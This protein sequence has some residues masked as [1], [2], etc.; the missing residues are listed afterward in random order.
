MKPI[1][2]ALAT[3]AALAVGA[4]LYVMLTSAGVPPYDPDDASRPESA[5]GP[6]ET[7]G[8]R[9]FAGEHGPS[10]NGTRTPT[11][12]R[13]P[14]PPAGGGAGEEIDLDARFP[15]IDSVEENGPASGVEAYRSRTVRGRV[16]D[17]SGAAIEGARVVALARGDPAERTEARTDVAGAFSIRTRS[18]DDDR[19]FE[20]TH[21]GYGR[22]TFRVR[23]SLR[24]H[25]GETVDVGDLVLE[26]GGAIAGHLRTTEG[27]PVSSLEVVLLGPVPGSDATAGFVAEGHQFAVRRSG[28]DGAFAFAGLSPG[29]YSL[30]VHP[31][32]GVGLAA[33]SAEIV[34]AEGEEVRDAEIVLRATATV[35]CLIVDVDGRPAVALVASLEPLESPAPG[36]GRL[37]SVMSTAT[38][39]D[40]RVVFR[41]AP[42]GNYRVRIEGVGARIVDPS[43]AE[44]TVPESGATVAITV[45]VRLARSIEGR[46][47]DRSGRPVPSLMVIA[48]PTPPAA[49]DS[50]PMRSGFTSVEGVF[51][52]TGL[53]DD[54]Y[55]LDVSRVGAVPGSAPIATVE[56]VEA[57]ATGVEIVV[58]L[59]R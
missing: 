13:D 50:P 56:A 8:G 19:D 10:A 54:E 1:L 24:G 25:G 26:R 11:G 21:D 12:P 15:L 52:I 29:R 35:E 20:V 33:A 32:P 30:E 7:Q 46:I 34:I 37:A 6:S 47:V 2:L 48:T 42:P 38:G 40:G 9:E 36:A 14:A 18:G 49:G 41:N 16:I 5:P 43:A 28:E 23:P 59:D 22:R 51:A 3:L 17:T 53:H 45:Y 55:R 44:L 4:L 39:P 31:D 57:G 27:A 58:D